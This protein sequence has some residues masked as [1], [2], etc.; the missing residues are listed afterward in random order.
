[1][2]RR[3]Q[4]TAVIL[5]A[6]FVDLIGAFVLFKVYQGQLFGNKDNSQELK[7]E[8]DFSNLGFEEV[9]K[10]MGERNPDEADY[11]QEKKIFEEVVAGESNVSPPN[12]TS[13]IVDYEA[14]K[15]EED[16]FLEILEGR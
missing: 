13:G 4:I 1:M 11:E 12:R 8:E 9:L 2:S 10:R 5:F 15:I 3:Q 7:T 16:K 14:Y 6:V